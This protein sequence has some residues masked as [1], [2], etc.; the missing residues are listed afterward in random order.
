MRADRLISKWG[1]WGKR[2]TREIIE[3]G[4]VSCNGV[5]I[6]DGTQ[7]VGKFDLVECNG[8]I[9]QAQTAR[10]LMLHKPLGFVS[11]TVDS[12]HETVVELIQESW[13][14]ELHLAGRLDRFTSGL[15]ILTNDSRFSEAITEPSKK[16]GKRYRVETDQPISDEMVAAFRAG[17]WFAKEEVKT[18]PAE[19]E[20]LGDRC[21]LLTIYEG[22]H[23]QVKRMFARF[24]VKVTALHREAIGE[25]VLAPELSPGEWRFLLPDELASFSVTE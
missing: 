9:V 21:C 5:P 19:V 20:V 7:Q 15:I 14:G 13:S 2:R 17:L 11:A 25:L 16:V 8:Q 3:A 1:S 12:E 22:K 23:H 4:G 24:E 6:K 10:Y 18:A